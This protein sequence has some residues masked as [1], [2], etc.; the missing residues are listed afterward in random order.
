MQPAQSRAGRGLI[1]WSQGQLA[2]AAGVS[3]STVRDFEAGRRIPIANNMAAI[4]AALEGAG[5][6]LIEANDHG[7]GVMLRK[8]GGQ[9]G[10]G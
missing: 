8:S 10:A 9:D 4:R 3:L 6:V 7:A 5:V 1:A 2:E